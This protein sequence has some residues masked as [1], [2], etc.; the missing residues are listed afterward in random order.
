M[1]EQ[2]LLTS[3]SPHG[4]AERDAPLRLQLSRR[5][6]FDLTRLSRS[7]NGREATVVSRPSLFGNPWRLDLGRDGAIA[8]HR[9]WLEGASSDDEIALADPPDSAWLA[10]RR[11]QVLARLGALQGRNLACWCAPDLQ[12]HADTLIA[13]ANF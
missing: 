11:E 7:I 13:L 10:Q 2:P 3:S 8:L 12:C 5:K 9:R 1:Q 4:A 6:G